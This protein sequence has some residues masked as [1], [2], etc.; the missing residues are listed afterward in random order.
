MEIKGILMEGNE[1]CMS[2]IG[3]LKVDDNTIKICFILCYL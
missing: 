2:K 1:N 3:L